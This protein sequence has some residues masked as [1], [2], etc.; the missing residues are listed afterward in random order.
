MPDP[1]FDIPISLDTVPFHEMS[2]CA[3]ISQFTERNGS[4]ATN[5][6]VRIR[7]CIRERLYR[8]ATTGSAQGQDSLKAL[9]PVATPCVREKRGVIL[10]VLGVEE[11]DDCIEVR[12]DRLPLYEK[13]LKL[14]RPG[15]A[16]PS[17]GGRRSICMPFSIGS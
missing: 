6:K 10:P 1:V 7:K 11:P 13:I 4:K 14:I 12:K 5:Q 16:W 15:R 9:I 8:I 3:P 17:P 2:A